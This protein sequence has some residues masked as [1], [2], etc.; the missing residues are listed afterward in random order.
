[1]KSVATHIMGYKL[2]VLTMGVLI[3]VV[4]PIV[5]I[6]DFISELDYEI[7][8]FDI[9]NDLEDNEKEKTLIKH[10]KFTHNSVIKTLVEVIHYNVQKKYSNFVLE[11]D[12]PPPQYM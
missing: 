8:E 5:E 4:K 12:I 11:I 1:M 6:A 9:D 2:V 3:L 7:S 10:N